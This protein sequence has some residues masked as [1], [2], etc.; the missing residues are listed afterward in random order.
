MTL[1]VALEPGET[2]E[3]LLA[4]ARMLAHAGGWGVRIVHVAEGDA[5]PRLAL[6]ARLVTN[7]EV[8]E[9]S[10]E[11]VA[12]ILEEAQAGDVTM[13]AFSLR[14]AA[15]GEGVGRV[16]DALM[17]GAGRPLLVMRPGVNPVGALKR[18]L[19][20][21]SGNPTTS[22]A[23]RFAEDHLCER[24][25]EIVVLHV[26]T[27]ERE[28][29]PGSMTAPRIVDQEQYEWS[30]WHE[31]FR[32]RFAPCPHGRRHRTVIKAGVPGKVIVAEATAQKVDLLIL[33]WTARLAA[34]PSRQVE[35]LLEHAPCPLLLVPAATALPL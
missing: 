24:G 14:S 22:E 28:S 35:D 29:E 12:A 33:A 7:T 17:R 31:E 5:G 30:D 20:P 32:M 18:I 4:S 1:L 8:R 13:L 19:V 27:A 10:G 15:H 23:M 3:I 2:G 16:A 21:L 9:L 25:R 26:A 6:P 11:P 34:R